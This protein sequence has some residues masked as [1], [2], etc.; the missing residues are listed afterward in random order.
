MVGTIGVSLQGEGQLDSS[1][2]HGKG[3]SEFPLQGEGQL[4][5]SSL[6]GKLGH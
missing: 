5:S 3:Q 2:S 1:S 4:D 6:Q